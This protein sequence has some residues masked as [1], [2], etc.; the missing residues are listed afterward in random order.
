MYP[1]PSFFAKVVIEPGS[2][3]ALASVRP[4]QPI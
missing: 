4:K 3:P 1:S 2:E